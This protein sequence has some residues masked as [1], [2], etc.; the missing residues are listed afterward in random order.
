MLAPGGAH[1]DS[2]EDHALL[3][4]KN[5]VDDTAE[6]DVE[7][8]ETEQ[9]EDD[10]EDLGPGSQR[11]DVS[12]A[13]RAHGDDAEVERVDYGVGFDSRVVVSVEGVD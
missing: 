8:A 6:E 13:D 7:E 9:D 12:V 5:V 4:I 3:E 10:G 11:G 2:G 1:L